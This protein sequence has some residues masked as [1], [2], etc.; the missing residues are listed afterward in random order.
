MPVGLASTWGMKKRDLARV[1]GPSWPRKMGCLLRQPDLR[2]RL[3][4]FGVSKPSRALYSIHSDA[5]GVLSFETSNFVMGGD[6]PHLQNSA[7]LGQHKWL[8][9]S[10]SRL[11]LVA[12]LLLMI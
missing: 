9:P 3:L 4:H 5:D 2:F 8:G 7:A 6:P 1:A 12:L 11:F 10:S